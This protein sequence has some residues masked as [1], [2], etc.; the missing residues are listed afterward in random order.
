MTIDTECGTDAG[1][2]IAETVLDA[3]FRWAV[4]LGSGTVA[5]AERHAFER[6]LQ[7]APEHGVAWR[8]I[9]IIE[10]EFATARGDASLRVL[11]R[12][13]AR[14]R[15]RRFGAALGTL[16]SLVLIAGVLLLPLRH[17]WQ[18]QYVTGRGE[19][20]QLVLDGGALIR[21]D[22]D[23][24]LDLEQADGAPAVHLHRG[25]ILVDSGAAAPAAKPRIVTA[26]G[27]FTPIG[28]RFVITSDGDGA[29]LALLQGRVRIDA[30]GQSIDARAGQRW[31]VGEHGIEAL[32][33]DGLQ[34]G[35]WRDGVVEADAAR[36]DDVLAELGRHRRGWLRCDPAIASLRVTG[37]FHLD[38]TDGAL[39]ALE[40]SLPVRVERTTDWWVSVRAR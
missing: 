6:W 10:Q 25:R 15:V 13:D 28:T 16:L 24:A 39:R 34:P 29:E 31:R 4:V 17:L 19:Q 7:A 3:A 18:G 20:R 36:L 26:H 1:R 37:L 21:L 38:D 23:T 5:A 33:G 2:D 40:Q 32:A 35:A 14:R 12:V 9:Q 27:S 11:D 22:T 8:R 30:G